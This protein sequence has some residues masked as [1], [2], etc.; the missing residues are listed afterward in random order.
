MDHHCFAGNP[1]WRIAYTGGMVPLPSGPVII[2]FGAGLRPLPEGA[3]APWEVIGDGS[4]YRAAAAAALRERHPDALLLLSGGWLHPAG[5]T[6]AEAMRGYVTEELGVPAEGVVAETASRDTA[7]NVRETVKL[8]RS[9]GLA[10]HALFLVTG[11]K[12]LERAARYF[13]AWGLTVTPMTPGEILG[14]RGT[15]MGFPAGWDD[16]TPQDRRRE[17]LLLALQRIDPRGKLASMLARR[18]RA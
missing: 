5:L 4:R 9:L 7:G 16:P 12:H 10:E 8:L 3:S 15:V 18:L 17:R 6:E 2:A 13:R 11:P 1:A 14:E